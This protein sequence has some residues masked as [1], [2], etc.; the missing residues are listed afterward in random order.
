VFIT[1]SRP[2]LEWLVRGAEPFQTTAITQPAG[3]K[4][5]GAASGEVVLVAGSKSKSMSWRSELSWFLFLTVAAGLFAL[6]FLNQ[7]GVHP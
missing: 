4:A 3:G 5:F 2:W 7:F 6:P 1:G